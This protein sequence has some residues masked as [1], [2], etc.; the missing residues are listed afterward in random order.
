MRQYLTRRLLQSAVVLLVVSFITFII[1]ALFHGTVARVILGPRATQADIASFNHAHFYDRH[2][3]YQYYQYMNGLFHGDFGHSVLRSTLN[4][5][6]WDILM[7]ALPRTLW[8]AVFPLVLALLIA[9]PLG[10]TQAWRRNKPFDYIATF[11]SFTL[12]STPAY[13]MSILLVTAFAINFE[14]FPGLIPSPTGDGIF[15][16]LIFMIQNWRAFVLPV[17]ILTLLSLAGFSRFTRGAVLDAIVQDYVRTA[18]AKGAGNWRVL[19]RHVLRNALIPLVTLLGLSLP[20]LFAGA[21][22]VEEVFNYPGM[23]YITVSH[24]IGRDIPVVMAATL[25]IAISTVVGNLLADLALVVADP[26]I[27]IVSK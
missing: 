20:S 27:R 19:S 21:L 7:P 4:R 9:I 23:G 24:T 8:L 18:R 17:G 14:I 6:A 15:D 5:P 26:R 12:Y 16:P 10:T 2:I 13:L 11:M 25:I 22:I 1:P 3:L